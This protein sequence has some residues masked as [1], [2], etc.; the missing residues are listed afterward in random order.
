MKIVRPNQTLS[1][2]AYNVLKNAIITGKFKENES[3]PEEKIA[4]ELGISRTPIRDA[5]QRLAIEGLVIH[6]TGKPAV[7]ASFTKEDSLN[8]MEV[9]SILEVKNV[10]KIISK[11]NQ[12]FIDDLK[13]NLEEQNNA[14]SNDDYQKFIELDREFHLLLASRNSNVKFRE[15]IQQVNT[16]VNRAFLILSSTVPQS[17]TQALSEHHEIVEALEKKDVNLAKNNMIVHMMHVE[18]RFLSYYEEKQ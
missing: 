3:L 5:L 9:R 2:Q 18:K 15:L 8:F 6:S 16:G 4:K 1:E 10:E 14:I 11:V 17:A 13:D 12:A 7:V